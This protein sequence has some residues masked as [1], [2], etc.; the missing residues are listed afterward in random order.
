MAKDCKTVRF[1]PI[2]ILKGELP[3]EVMQKFSKREKY[4]KSLVGGKAPSNKVTLFE[5]VE[6]N[7]RVVD[8]RLLKK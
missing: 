3:W 2:D 1:V 4:Q 6:V 8:D 7:L 5:R